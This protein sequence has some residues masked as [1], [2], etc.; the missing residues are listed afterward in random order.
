MVLERVR[1]QTQGSAAARKGWPSE[2]LGTVSSSP[3]VLTLGV[4]TASVACE[5]YQRDL[6]RP[7][8]EPSGEQPGR[9]NRD[10]GAVGSHASKDGR[11]SCVWNVELHG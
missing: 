3:D 8:K 11:K 10:E 7:P 2:Q 5:M 6:P 9:G 4:Q 1:E